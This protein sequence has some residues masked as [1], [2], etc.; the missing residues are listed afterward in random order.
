MMR[1]KPYLGM[2]AGLLALLAVTSGRTALH[3]PVQAS[4]S[5]EAAGESELHPLER[6]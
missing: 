1:A 6:D 4:R 3:A 5:P 2:F